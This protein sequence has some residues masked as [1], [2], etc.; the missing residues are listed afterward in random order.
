MEQP[1]HR[2]ERRD[3]RERQ[4]QQER[5]QHAAPARRTA[6][7]TRR[8]SGA[9][10][11]SARPPAR[12]GAPTP[13]RPFARGS[14]R[15]TPRNVSAT[16]R[17]AARSSAG[18]S[19]GGSSAAASPARRSTAA[20]TPT[21]S[22]TARSIAPVAVAVIAFALVIVGLTC[23]VRSCSAENETAPGTSATAAQTTSTVSFVAVGDNLPE[24]VLAEYAWAL[25]GDHYDFR[26][27]YEFVEP[28]IAAADI[29]YVKQEVHLDDSIGPHGY[30]SFNAPE[31]L[32]DD[33]ISV[34]FD[35][36]GSASNHIYDWGYFGACAR[37]REV[38]N[39]KNAIFAGSN[40]NAAEAETIATFEKGGIR[41]AFLDYTYGVNGYSPSDL[42]WWEVNFI[43]EDRLERDVARAH[44]LA[45][46]VIAAMH[47]GTENFTGI[48]DYQ[49][50]YAQ[51]LADLNV[52]LVLGSHPHVIGPVEW[53]T[54]TDG[55]Q[56]LVA[57]SLGNFLSRHEAPDAYN[58]LEGMLSCD[59]VRQGST[60]TIENATWTP[61]VNHTDWE[62]YYFRVIPLGSYTNELAANGVAMCQLD[63]AVEW[64]RTTSREIVGNQIA[65]AD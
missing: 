47:W 36:I 2:S 24:T 12:N 22:T 10:T 40:L 50:K 61:L 51:L 34:G 13:A 4:P 33:L 57:Y 5:V 16:A 45:D 49:A 60:V 52:D 64:V 63:N 48:D 42:D 23:A 55:H 26:P 21:E 17:P 19:R 39:S 43:S 65:F 54:G 3:R 8:A 31:S 41:F 15:A 11:S 53:L 18:S 44:E 14:A 58:E 9:Q 7:G 56:T 38:W 27:I 37:N 46:V 30:P 62:N 28:A 20:G 59:F 29:A 6:S 25:G 35:V 32:A 1:D